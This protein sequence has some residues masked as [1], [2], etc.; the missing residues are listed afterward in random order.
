MHIY[1]IMCVVVRKL[2]E[3]GVAT[4]KKQSPANFLFFKPT[5]PS[6]KIHCCIN[7]TKSKQKAVCE[8]ENSFPEIL[9]KVMASASS[10][11]F[12]DFQD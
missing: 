3:F 11:Y 10:M 7:F 8:T 9:T 12:N 6:K 1:R 2:L 5:F 4:A